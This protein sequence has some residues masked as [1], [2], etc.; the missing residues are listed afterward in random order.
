MR[1]EHS[2]SIFWKKFVIDTELTQ[3]KLPHLF[4]EV[5]EKK[6]KSKLYFVKVWLNKGKLAWSDH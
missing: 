6:K 2:V 5:S 3:S 1:E 4:Q